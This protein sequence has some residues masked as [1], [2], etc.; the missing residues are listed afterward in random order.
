MLNPNIARRMKMQEMLAKSQ[1]V[2]KAEAADSEKSKPKQSPPS[3]T[4]PN[5]D[6]LDVTAERVVDEL[7][8]GTTKEHQRV[9]RQDSRNRTELN[10]HATLQNSLSVESISSRT[11]TSSNS[12]NRI[13]ADQRRSSNLT[14]YP[15]HL[16]TIRSPVPPRSPSNSSS[17]PIQ[18]LAS[19]D[20]IPNQ[21]HKSSSI[22]R[23]S[24]SH[25]NVSYNSSDKPRKCR[26]MASELLG[27]E[28][29]NINYFF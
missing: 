23:R 9:T 28:L 12:D 11:R 19:G 21:T 14:T 17:D 26:K 8:S 24:P 7:G 16:S 15:D 1:A 13:A 10:S 4:A 20:H 5:S 27:T 25:R 6:R 3:I 2:K 22:G 29:K 18:S